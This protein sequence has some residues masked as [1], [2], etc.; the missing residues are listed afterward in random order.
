MKSSLIIQKKYTS[1]SLLGLFNLYSL[2]SHNDV[3]QSYLSQLLTK[4]IFKKLGLG[5]DK[6]FKWTQFSVF[7]SSVF[8]ETLLCLE[9]NMKCSLMAHG[10]MA[11]QLNIPFC[12]LLNC[13]HL[14]R[15][16]PLTA[17]ALT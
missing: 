12:G 17:E 2:Y 8:C 1:P 7:V 5:G 3:R 13:N 6:Y 4:E 10:L 11:V 9:Q 15:K 16:H 14:L